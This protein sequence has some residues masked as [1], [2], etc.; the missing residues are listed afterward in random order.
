MTS[1]NRKSA[2]KTTTKIEI[3]LKGRSDNKIGKKN[4]KERNP[5]C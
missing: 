4:Q 2:K 1:S 3:N 5:K